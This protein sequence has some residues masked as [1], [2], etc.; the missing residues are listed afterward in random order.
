MVIFYYTSLLIRDSDKGDFSAEDFKDMNEEKKN[1]R[2]AHLRRI[3]KVKAIGAARI[4]EG[5]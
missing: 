1:H 2:C 5:F 3:A 4:I